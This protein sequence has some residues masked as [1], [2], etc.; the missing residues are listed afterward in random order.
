M[1][2]DIPSAAKARS[3][4]FIPLLTILLSLFLLQALLF[5]IMPKHLGLLFSL[6]CGSSLNLSTRQTLAGVYSCGEQSL[7]CN[8][9]LKLEDPLVSGP[10]FVFQSLHSFVFKS[11][12]HCVF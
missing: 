7:I 1:L 8:F 5:Y 12:L 10:I 2:P 9:L 3:A 4:G 6:I 11:V